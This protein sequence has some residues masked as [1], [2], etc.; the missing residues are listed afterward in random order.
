MRG[1]PRL[2]PLIAAALAAAIEVLY[3]SLINGQ[4]EGGIEGRV[5]FVAGSLAA[6][7]LLGVVGAVVRRRLLAV[8]ALSTSASILL[9][10]TVLG[11]ASIGL[12]IAV[13]AFMMVASLAQ[14]FRDDS[15]SERC[16]ALVA[17]LA[18]LTVTIFGLYRPSS[19]DC[20]SQPARRPRLRPASLRRLRALPSLGGGARTPPDL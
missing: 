14:A 10:W 3:V 6:G 13:P 15:V 19:P 17:M 5:L 9:I 11:A 8:A 1:R 2:L 16:L 12:L 20:R 18:T 7:A 4:D